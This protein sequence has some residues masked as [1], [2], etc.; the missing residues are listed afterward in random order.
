MHNICVLRKMLIWFLDSM[1]LLSFLLILYLHVTF[2][3]LKFGGISLLLHWIHIRVLFIII[4]PVTVGQLFAEIGSFNGCSLQSIVK[5]H[6]NLFNLLFNMFLVSFYIIEITVSYI[7][8]FQVFLYLTALFYLHLHL[9]FQ[10]SFLTANFCKLMFLKSLFT[11]HFCIT[12]FVDVVYCTYFLNI[13]LQ[14]SI[15]TNPGPQKEKIKNLICCHLNVNSQIRVHKLSKISQLQV[16]NSVYKHDFICIS[17]TFFDSSV[18]EGGKNIELGGYS[19]LKADHQSNS[20]QGGVCICYKE[21]LGVRIVKSLSF[22]VCII[23]EVSI[24]NSKGYVG[25]LYRSL[26]Q[27][28]FE[29]ENFLSNFEK[30]LNGTT[31]CN[32][33]FTII[34]G[35]FNARSSVWWTKDKTANEGTQFESLTTVHGFHQL[36]S[37]P[38]HLLTQISSCID[39]IFTNQ[40]NLIVDSDI[41][42][43]LHS[44]YHYQITYSKLRANVEGIKKPIEFVN[45]EV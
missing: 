1:F 43:S 6:L 34:L 18:Q 12:S 4:M 8:K 20:K 23:C 26:S 37:Q 15:E 24:Q 33:L 36:I 2:Y 9:F 16:R 38:T 10:P 14:G 22:G 25:V 3:I 30:V 27:D 44:N 42:P 5:L 21:I 31:S 40:P 28:S 39:L 13:L 32:S 7:T 29:F 17:D 41:Y 35:D 11:N 19:F 45:L